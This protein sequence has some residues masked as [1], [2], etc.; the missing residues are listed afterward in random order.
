[1]VDL[2]ERLE[3]RNKVATRQSA[4]TSSNGQRT[5]GLATVWTSPFD[6]RHDALL[7]Q[8]IANALSTRFFSSFCGRAR[9]IHCCDAAKQLVPRRVS[10]FFQLASCRC[11]VCFRSHWHHP[12]DPWTHR[13]ML[14]TTIVVGAPSDRGADL[15]TNVVE[16][17]LSI[18]FAVCNCVANKQ[19]VCVKKFSFCKIKNMTSRV[20]YREEGRSTF[21]K[22]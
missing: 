1:M 14:Y 7:R 16:S 2:A 4:I 6:V 20:L 18:I 13:P 21:L 3:R 9:G 8:R 15:V 10:S 19:N 12:S 5:G 11:P 22:N 17:S